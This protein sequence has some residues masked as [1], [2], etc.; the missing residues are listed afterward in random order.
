M[1]KLIG[2]GV[3]VGDPEMLTIKAVNALR[4]ADAVILPRANTKTYSTAFEI[5]KQYMKDDI[6][7]IYADFTTVDDD[8][9]REEDR[10]LYAKVVNDCIK[11]GKTVAF[12]TIGDPMTFSTFVYVM[13]LL[14]K[15][16]EVQTIPGITS[17]ASIAA[18]LNTP[19]VM[20]DE[21]LKIVPISKDTDI[22]KEINSSDNVVFMKVTRNLERLKDAFKKTGNMDN[23]VL[24][25]NCGKADEKVIYD[26]ENITREDISYFST[27]LLKKGGLSYV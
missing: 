7:K 6:E 21:T 12:I 23:V 27:I 1:S 8:K 5:A 24:V 20:G 2:I 3:G 15:D 19:L 10:L 16:V 14:E 4:E 18:R 17:F 11:A 13:E 9:L 22:V 25:S 26:L